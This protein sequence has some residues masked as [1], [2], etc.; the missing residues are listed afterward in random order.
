LT[1]P[2]GPNL[3]NSASMRWKR[4]SRSKRSVNSES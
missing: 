2:A 3:C 4:Q 1:P